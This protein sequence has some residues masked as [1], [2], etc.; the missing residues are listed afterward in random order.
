MAG[1]SSAV[2]GLIPRST[3]GRMALGAGGALAVAGGVA[4]NRRNRSNGIK[5]YDETPSGV[6]SPQKQYEWMR[7][8]GTS[9]SMATRD[10]ASRYPGYDTSSLRM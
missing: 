4:M 2:R 8:G 5:V 9:H 3:G 6:A 1:M 7:E 10:I